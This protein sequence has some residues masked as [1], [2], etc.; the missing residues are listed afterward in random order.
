MQHGQNMD[1]QILKYL[2]GELDAAERL[3]LLRQ[4]N[5]DSELKKQFIE[6]KNTYALLHLC[7]LVDDKDVN[8]YGYLKFS[9]LIRAK[10]IRTFFFYATGYAAAIAL[11]VLSTYIITVTHL[12][13]TVAEVENTLYV[14]AG[15]RMKLTLSDGTDVWLNSQTK[16]TYPGIFSGKERR[17]RVEGEAFFEVARN[18]EKP[19]IVSSKGVEMKV[20]GTKFNVYSYPEEEGIETSLLEGSLKVYYPETET[21]AITLRPQ[22]RVT[23]KRE[24]ME[25]DILRHTDYFLW[26]EG[27]YSFKNEPLIHILKKLELYFD[28]R[29]IVKDP[30]ISGWEYTGK[31]RQR[32]GIDEILRMIQKIH[33]FHITKEE[34]KNIL[35][36]SR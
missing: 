26:K 3:N 31:F 5:T 11:L 21:Q 14:P 23:V 29:I 6:H 36:L 9:R 10:R 7:D 34:D 12:K 2:Q 20:L 16:L 30:S 22:E 24:K 25:V 19:F 15:Q 32:D 35:I 17:V 13:Q 28:V 33:K 4:L 18:P 8:K 27:I 1:E